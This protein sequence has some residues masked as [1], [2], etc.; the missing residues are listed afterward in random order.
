MLFG[1]GSRLLYALTRVALPPLALAHVGLAEYGLWAACFVIVGYLGMTASG[2][3][4]VYLRGVARHHASG[5]VAAASRLVSTGV[6]TLCA[7]SAALLAGLHA[8]LPGLLEL[9]NVPAS[10][11][12]LAAVLWLAACA[13]FLVDMSLGAFA[14]VLHAVGR[15]RT[16]QR[17]WIAAFVLETAALV[18][19]L[20]A[21]LGVFAL[22][23]AFALRYAFSIVATAVAARRALPGLRLSPRLFEPRLL[24]EFAALGAGMQLSSLA[25]TALHSADRLLA[26][27]LLGPAATAVV[28]L[29]GKLP[30]TAG[31]LASQASTVALAA[32]A[33]HAVQGQ[34]RALSQVYVDAMRVTVGVLSLSLPF[35]I[36]FA[37]LVSVA[38]LGSQQATAIVAQVMPWLAAGLMA[39]LLTG[40]AT[41]AQRGRGRLGSDF[42]LHGL[43]LAMLL[44]AWL[45]WPALRSGGETDVVHLAAAIGAGQALAATL[46]LCL[47]HR[48]EC[49]SFA[50]LG[51]DVV[52]PV[53]AAFALALALAALAAAHG[54]AAPATRSSALLQLGAALALWLALA[55]PVLAVLL[56]RRDEWQALRERARRAWPH[57][58]AGWRKA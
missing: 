19:L 25:A 32:S 54:A 13:V 6:L 35:L 30:V 29:A 52:L 14:G 33:R 9:L 57:S 5:D 39:H 21:G 28:D 41:A 51:R 55:L 7:L 26:G 42:A 17:I 24:R 44:A 45:A 11:H 3:T 2:F 47:A 18:L 50:G 48:R 15:V 23:W 40:P 8:A 22:V 16:E 53:A 36:V 46:F 34:A 4:V 38:W 31:S 43:R 49:G 37:P 58:G 27:A 12:R 10:Q 1:I 56:L 20:H